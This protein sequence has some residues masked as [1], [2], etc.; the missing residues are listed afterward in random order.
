MSQMDISCSSPKNTMKMNHKE[1]QL[2]GNSRVMEP[3]EKA[4][5]GWRTL[6]YVR[7]DQCPRKSEKSTENS[8]C[9]G[10]KQ[11]WDMM[12]VSGTF[13]LQRVGI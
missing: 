6:Q 3:K 2:M 7:Q 4:C 11:P 12:F 8:V 13:L 10:R 9:G 1:M 5:D